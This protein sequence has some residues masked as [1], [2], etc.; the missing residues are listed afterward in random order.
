TWISVPVTNGTGTGQVAFTVSPNPLPVSR[1]GTLLI[2]GQ[3][4]TIS[5]AGIV[6]NYTIAPT[7]TNHTYL[8]STGSVSVTTSNVCS[9]S[10]FNS[11]GWVT[12]VSPLTTVTGNA[13]VV[14]TLVSNPTAIARSG[15]LTIAG[16]PYS[17]TQAGATCGWSV[18][19]TTF[20]HPYT[21]DTGTVAIS[22]LI[23]CPWAVTNTNAWVFLV[24]G[25][26]GSAPGT[27]TYT[28]A[29]NTTTNARTGRL[30]ING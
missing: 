9:W 22:T 12:I 17:I 14:Y 7:A 20:T 28:V 21:A 30:N 6:C 25:T 19:P 8:A 2:G 26:N 4:F 27:L 18:Q 11:N 15:F 13:S 1:T 23:G 29:L 3:P 5:Q 16:Q 10:V 24:S